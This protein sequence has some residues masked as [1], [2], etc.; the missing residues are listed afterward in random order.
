MVRSC[1]NKNLKNMDNKNY[2]EVLIMRVRHFVNLGYEFPVV[3]SMLKDSHSV[4]DIFLAYQG[5]VILN[6]DVYEV[7]N[8]S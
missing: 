2:I 4:S 5:A 6:K 8:E 1:W 3:C 7:L